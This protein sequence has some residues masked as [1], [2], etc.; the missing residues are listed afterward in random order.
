MFL[1]FWVSSFF[2][3]CAYS[4]KLDFF[5]SQTISLFYL[6]TKLYLFSISNELL[7]YLPVNVVLQLHHI[8]KYTY[9]KSSVF[10]KF[11]VILKFKPTTKRR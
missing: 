10:I 2:L 4:F 7:V 8:L 1:L 11:H 3:F 6:A 9:L 5:I